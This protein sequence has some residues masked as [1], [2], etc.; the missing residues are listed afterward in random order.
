MENK[1][2]NETEIFNVTAEPIRM[3][4]IVSEIGTQLNRKIPKISI[5]KG[6]LRLI[7]WTN[8]KSLRLKPVLN[9]SATVEKWLSEDVFS[10]E[11]ISRKYDFRPRT[12]IKEAIKK[13][14]EAYKMN[15][16]KES[17]QK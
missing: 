7:F 9:S 5:P 11:S 1:T 17:N 3:K 14:I 13:Q 15:E 4:D 10:G 16:D 8:E 2:T 12:P 6:I